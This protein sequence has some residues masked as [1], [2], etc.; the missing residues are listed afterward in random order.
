MLLAVIII[1]ACHN[2]TILVP[3][4]LDFVRTLVTFHLSQS[5]VLRLYSLPPFRRNFGFRHSNINARFSSETNKHYYHTPLHIFYFLF[6]F[7]H[8][9]RS[10]QRFDIHS[11]HIK[12]HVNNIN[13][14]SRPE[15]AGVTI[16]RVRKFYPEYARLS[17]YL[18][19]SLDVKQGWKDSPA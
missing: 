16:G 9:I 15:P 18:Y 19:R 3:R 4:D 12:L 5:H 13:R 1:L 10:P 14:H 8:G 7:S 6:F 17:L 11:I 2:F